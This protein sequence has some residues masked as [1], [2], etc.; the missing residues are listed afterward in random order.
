MDDSVEKALSGALTYLFINH[1]IL[2]PECNLVQGGTAC[3]NI[4]MSR[5]THNIS[6]ISFGM[7]FKQILINCGKRHNY[8]FVCGH[9]T[10]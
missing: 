3:I 1:L 7:L 8:V 2:F 9:P 10:D 4:L 6:N 5:Y